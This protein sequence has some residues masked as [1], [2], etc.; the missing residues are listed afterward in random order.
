LKKTKTGIRRTVLAVVVAIALVST[1]STAYLLYNKWEQRGPPAS[2]ARLSIAVVGGAYGA[3]KYNLVVWP[4]LLALRTG[5]SVAN[6]SLPGAGFAADAQGRQAIAYQADRAQGVHPQIIVMAAG[7]DDEAFAGTGNVTAG[8]REAITR[9][10]L[11]GER[12]FIIGPTWYDTPPPPSITSVSD[13][14]HRLADA[15]GV[16]FLDALNPPWLTPDQMLPDF[17]APTDEG[18]SVIA[19]KVAAWL[20]TQVSG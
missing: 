7:S 4:T 13:E 16:P 3:G 5:W 12:A 1:L 10:K 11:A 8:A 17:S 6:F 19:D 14:L 20:R 2:A 9:I 15:A 18:Q